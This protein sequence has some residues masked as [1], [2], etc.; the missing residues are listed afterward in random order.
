MGKKKRPTCS[1]C[2]KY[3]TPRCKWA[4]QNLV[5]FPEDPVCEEFEAKKKRKT[6]EKHQLC[7]HPPPHNTVGKGLNRLNFCYHCGAPVI[8]NILDVVA[9]LRKP[10]YFSRSE[11][12]IKS[13][14][15]TADGKIEW[16]L[17][18]SHIRIVNY[19]VKR[20]R[21]RPRK[22]KVEEEYDDIEICYDVKY[23]EIKDTSKPF[24]VRTKGGCM[25]SLKYK[26][27]CKWWSLSKEVFGWMMRDS[28]EIFRKTKIP[29]TEMWNI[30]NFFSRV[31]WRLREKDLRAIYAY[32]LVKKG[33][34]WKKAT[35][36]AELKDY[37]IVKR[38]GQHVE[39]ILKKAKQFPN[40]IE[41]PY[42]PP[43]AWKVN[44]RLY[45]RW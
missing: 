8:E 38:W 41:H 15:L 27:E 22:K 29:A 40:I 42:W 23:E 14:H 13:I 19:Y 45:W 1:E 9:Y 31:C 34:T 37:R 36:T 32:F 30:I 7:E 35:K 43:D 24:G 4:K 16:L 39:A 21:G 28:V 44:G 3:R 5:A 12:I 11:G 10:R 18:P 2:V 33:F 20:R 25:P 17:N 6:R 26:R